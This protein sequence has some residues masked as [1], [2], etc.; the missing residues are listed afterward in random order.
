M[1]KLMPVVLVLAVVLTYQVCSLFAQTNTVPELPPV[2]TE[3]PGGG[4]M[5]LLNLIIT[6]LTPIVIFGIKKIVPKIPTVLLPV[7]APV[8]G[9]I[10]DF[11]L[12]KAGVDTGGT[13]AGAVW[14]ALG[15]WLRELQDQTKKAILPK[16]AEIPAKP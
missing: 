16:T 8:I 5:S 6:G 3:E 4:A 1:K 13:F 15:L 10:L 11:V 9:I 14:G 7:A 2:P 12:R